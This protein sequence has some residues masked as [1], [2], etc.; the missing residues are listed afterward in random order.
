[1][2]HEKID[3][4]LNIAP[5]AM[6]SPQD[7][8]CNMHLPN[9]RGLVMKDGNGRFLI[10]PKGSLLL[11]Y[12]L[13]FTGTISTHNCTHGGNLFGN[14]QAR[15]LYQNLSAATNIDKAKLYET[16]LD[17]NGLSEFRAW[18]VLMAGY[19]DQLADEVMLFLVLEFLS[20]IVKENATP[21]PH[22]LLKS[23]IIF[24]Y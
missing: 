6:E 8:K 24:D 3:K 23:S 19:D 22:K 5:A 11:F 17:L 14:R 7:V 1:L 9:N 13:F 18:Q 20:I 12:I 2:Q 21:P 10:A 16:C 15:C 4:I